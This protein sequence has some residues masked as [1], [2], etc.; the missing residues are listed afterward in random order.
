MLF[1]KIAAPN[2]NVAFGNFFRFMVSKLKYILARIFFINQ[3][4]QT[5][6]FYMEIWSFDN[7]PCVLSSAT[8]VLFL[9]VDISLK[10]LN[11]VLSVITQW[12]TETVQDNKL[13]PKHLKTL[14][15]VLT[16]CSNCMCLDKCNH[17]EHAKND[18]KSSQSNQSN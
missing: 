4:N 18:A 17:S 6:G 8:P 5:T 12:K 1:I 7:G 10:K 2:T 14:F 11:H 15:A 3:N 13:C 16:F 9:T